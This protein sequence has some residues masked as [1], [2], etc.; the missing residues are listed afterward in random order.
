MSSLTQRLGGRR[1]LLVEDEYFIAQ[2][3]RRSFAEVG[4]DIIGPLPTVA[5]AL[6][7]FERSAP[8]DAA[9]LD[10]NLRG[11]MV[12]PLV[13]RLLEANVTIVFVTG[14]DASEIPPKYRH[15]ARCEKPLSMQRLVTALGF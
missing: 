15:V 1:I 3:L 2:D 8:I 11:E 10:I 14:Y 9:V 12:Y 13:D 4:A 7:Q 6:L 5:D